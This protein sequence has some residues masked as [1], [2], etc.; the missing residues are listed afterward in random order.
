MSEQAQIAK[1][2][3][4][5]DYASKCA[6]EGNGQAHVIYRELVELRTMFGAVPVGV[7]H[8]NVWNKLAENDVIGAIREHRNTYGSTINDARAAVVALRDKYFPSREPEA[9]RDKN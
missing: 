2:M 5:M 4:I 1:I 8:P 3:R 7:V 6:S 9:F